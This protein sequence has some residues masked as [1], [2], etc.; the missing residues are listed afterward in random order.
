MGMAPEGRNGS[1]TT[2]A[3]RDDAT[4]SD[5][6]CGVS[7]PHPIA[8]NHNRQPSPGFSAEADKADEAARSTPG[9][10]SYKRDVDVLPRL[11]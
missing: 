3:R 11:C 9:N 6:T 4:T 5:A 8:A 2:K 10:P 1:S 7:L